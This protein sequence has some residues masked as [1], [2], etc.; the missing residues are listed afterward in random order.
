MKNYRLLIGLI[1]FLIVTNIATIL[2]V[3]RHIRNQKDAIGTEL[4]QEG[5]KDNKNPTELPDTQRTLFFTNA[6]ALDSNQQSAFREVNWNYGRQTK[7]IS[8]AMSLLR[9]ELLMALDQSE[10]DTALLNNLSDQ[11]GKKHTELKKMTITYYLGLKSI[12][13][14]DQKKALFVMFQKLLSPESNV[15]APN[16]R[17]EG[18][19]PQGQVQGRGPWWKDKKDSISSK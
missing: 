15:N 12:C 1:L 14:S 6:L 17:P 4:R 10:P 5:N 8:Q 11:I 2:T 7:E 9:E 18:R 16:G 3:V 13:N 19:G